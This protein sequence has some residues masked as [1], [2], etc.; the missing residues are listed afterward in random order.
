VVRES[1]TLEVE[2]TDFQ[3]VTAMSYRVMAE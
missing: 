3:G 1:W 2:L